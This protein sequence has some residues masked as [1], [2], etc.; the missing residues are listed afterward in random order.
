MRVRPQRYDAVAWW[1]LRGLVTSCGVYTDLAVGWCAV[2]H[3]WQAVS[4]AL[5]LGAGLAACW[6]GRATS[7]VDRTFRS[8]LHITAPTS[9]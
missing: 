1:R 9:R 2:S 6:D 4:M 3:R 8:L 5:N 7:P